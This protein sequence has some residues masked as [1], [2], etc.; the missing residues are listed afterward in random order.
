MDEIKRQLQN[1]APLFAGQ[2]RFDDWDG[3]GKPDCLGG[4]LDVDS[5]H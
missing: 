2:D 1:A 3:G 5:G 4:R